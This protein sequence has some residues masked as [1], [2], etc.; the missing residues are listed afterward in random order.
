MTHESKCRSVEYIGLE[1]KYWDEGAKRAVFEYDCEISPSGYANPQDLRNTTVVSMVGCPASALRLALADGSQTSVLPCAEDR[2]QGWSIESVS[3]QGRRFLVDLLVGKEISRGTMVVRFPQ[4]GYLR[5]AGDTFRIANS[6]YL[7]LEDISVSKNNLDKVVDNSKLVAQQSMTAVQFGLMTVSAS[8]AFVLMKIMQTLDFYV[9]IDCLYPEN[10]SMFLDWITN[11]VFH[12]MPNFFIGAV[13]QEGEPIY[14]KFADNGL[15]VHI[16]SNLGRFLTSVLILVS[17]KGLTWSFLKYKQWKYVKKVDEFL[18]TGFFFGMLE[19]NHMDIV[20]SLIIHVAQRDRVNEKSTFLKYIVIL[21]VS[22]FSLFMVSMYLF[23]GY[24]VSRLTKAYV[25]HAIIR[26]EDMKDEKFRFLLEDK[27]VGGNIFQRHFNLIQLLKDILFAVLLYTLYYHPLALIII[28]ALS[29][30]LLVIGLF[31]YPPYGEKSNNRVIQLT[32]SLYMLLNSSFCCLIMFGEY[33]SPDVKR[34]LMGNLMIV[35]VVL[36]I[37]CNVLIAVYR[38][39]FDVIQKCRKRKLKR[40]GKVGNN[41]ELIILENVKSS[42]DRKAS[43]VLELQLDNSDAKINM[44][45][46]DAVIEMKSASGN[47]GQPDGISHKYKT[48]NDRRS[49]NK[50]GLITVTAP[51]SNRNQTANSL[52]NSGLDHKPNQLRQVSLE[53]NNEA[54]QQLTQVSSANLGLLSEPGSIN[55]GKISRHNLLLNPPKRNRVIS[56][57]SG[58]TPVLFPH[59]ETR[60]A[61]LQEQCDTQLDEPNVVSPTNKQQVESKTR[62]ATSI[63]NFKRSSSQRKPAQEQVN[64]PKLSAVPP[65]PTRILRK[66]R[67]NTK[68]TTD[69]QEAPPIQINQL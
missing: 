43:D 27:N 46:E 8:Q 67:K 20:M 69:L 52:A 23:M 25:A 61:S 55:P 66:V 39:L 24:T 36:I 44:D 53:T 30:G 18:N 42:A 68:D 34:N 56:K 40:L 65:R 57:L 28:L 35:F 64:S 33:M 21:F 2:F 50:K 3:I 12:I 51:I 22:L 19:G 14:E 37:A 9:Y 60:K 5:D 4:F 16:F 49:K 7:I 62:S 1:R 41:K 10:F 32:N 17:L 58:Q 11:S 48:R 63:F 38:T 47:A 13:D 6:S 54:T 15:D 45:L 26:I 29:Q 59:K 31:L